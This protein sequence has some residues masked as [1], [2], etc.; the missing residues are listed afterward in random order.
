MYETGDF[1]ACRRLTERLLK[2]EPFDESLNEVLV[3]ATKE[4]EGALASRKAM[5][6]VES[7]FLSEVGELP[8]TLAQLKKEIKYRMN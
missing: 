7:Q 1:Q 3:R 6:K 8:P 2:I 5:S 4:I